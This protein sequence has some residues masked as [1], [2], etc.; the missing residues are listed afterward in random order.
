MFNS[1][2]FSVRNIAII[3]AISLLTHVVAR[4]LYN[5]IDKKA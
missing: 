4:P 2:F 1:H 3:T 5:R